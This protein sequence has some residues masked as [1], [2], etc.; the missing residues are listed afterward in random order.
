MSEAAIRAVDPSDVFVEQR[1]RL[2]RAALFWLGHPMMLVTGLIM[3]A[4]VFVALFGE[5]IAPRSFTEQLLDERLEG[6]SL[7]HPF[8]TDNLG[9]DMLSRTIVGARTSILVGF[10]VALIGTVLTTMVGLSSGFVGGWYD[11]VMQRFVDAIQSFPG[12][13][14]L[15]VLVTVVGASL[16][17][18]VFVISFSLMFQGSRTVRSAAIGTKANPYVE[19]ST[20]IGASRARTAVRH[21][22]PN[23]MSPI[24]IIATLAVGTA[25]IIESALAFLGFGIPPPRVSWGGL[26]SGDTKT[27]MFTAW[28][29]MAFPA[30][31]LSIAVLTVN[32]FG[33]ALRDVLDPRLR[34]TEQRR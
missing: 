7:R 4:F 9:R 19:A 25:I 18:I 17:N 22:L 15:L 13:I 2:Q 6:P 12:L 5:T 1:P 11:L 21:I 3:L 14:L 27:F 16:W 26:I 24:L 33:D 23:I 31:A 10:S 32:M 30:V 20:A 28:W 29:M 34:G 8:G